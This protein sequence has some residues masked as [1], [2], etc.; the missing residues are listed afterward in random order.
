MNKTHY[1][2][3]TKKLLV[4]KYGNI[5]HPSLINATDSLS[6]FLV[7]DLTEYQVSSINKDD[8]YLTQVL[9]VTLRYIK[10]SKR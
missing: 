3:D 8:G 2:D 4:R 6:P 1:D 7:L 10:N 9:C 5:A